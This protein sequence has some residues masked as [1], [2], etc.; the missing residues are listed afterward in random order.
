MER[1]ENSA[2]ADRAMT[3]PTAASAH[4]SSPRSS[5]LMRMPANDNQLLVDQRTHET[6]HLGAEASLR[7]HE[8]C[9]YLTANVLERPRLLEQTPDRCGGSIQ[10]EQLRGTDVEKRYSVFQFGQ[11]NLGMTTQD[12]ILWRPHRH[13]RGQRSP[14]VSC[15]RDFAPTLQRVLA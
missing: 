10:P 1:S 15:F 3:R 13:P 8:H 11:P 5:S 2:D 14:T 7:V 9:G 4:I 6:G 12:A